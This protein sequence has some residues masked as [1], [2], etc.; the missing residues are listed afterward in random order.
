M[1]VQLDSVLFEQVLINIVKNSIESI[2][3][4]GND[5][6]VTIQ[7]LSSPSRMIVS[8]NGIGISDEVAAHLFTPFYTSKPSGHGLGLILI[9]DVLNK[10]RCT[11]SLTTSKDDN[12]T[13]FKIRFPKQ[14]ND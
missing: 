2:E 13:R 5:G 9:S 8:D 3:M 10:H 7:V 6:V 4:K 14:T 12:L 1:F 11:Y